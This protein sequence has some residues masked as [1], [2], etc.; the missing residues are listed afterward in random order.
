[1]EELR[2]RAHSVGQNCYHLMWSPKFRLPLFGSKEIQTVCE[3]VLRMIAFQNKMYV[4]EIKVCSDHLHIFIEIPPTLSVSKAMQLLKGGSSRIL[5]RN[6]MFLQKE[7]RLW[8][9]G[10]FFRSV[11]SVKKEVIAHYIKHSQ[12]GYDFGQIKVNVASV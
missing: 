8:S 12:G 7:K 2:R 6:F 3:G 9:K 5:R 4:H 11:G 10:K 1:M